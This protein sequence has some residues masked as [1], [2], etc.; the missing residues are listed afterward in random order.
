MYDDLDT[1]RNVGIIFELSYYVRCENVLQSMEMD[2]V[3]IFVG[4]NCELLDGV[5]S[6]KRLHGAQNNVA[7]DS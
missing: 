1:G 3:H 5:R 6:H 7:Y 4:R 2:T